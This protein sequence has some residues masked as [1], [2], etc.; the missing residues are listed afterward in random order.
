MQGMGWNQWRTAAAGALLALASTMASAAWPERAITLVV[1][2]TPGTGIDVV[3][4]QLAARLPN[5]LGQAV[6][7]DNVAGASGNIGTERVARSAPDGYTFVVQASTLVMNKG[8]FRT[9]AY[10][11]LRDL[12]PV[13]L[14]SWGTLLLVTN[15]NVQKVST[16][17]Q[18]VA[19]ARA[20]PGKLTYGTPGVGTP[21]HLAMAQLL[22]ANGLDMLQVPFKGTAGAVTELLGG[23]LD[24]M[25]LPVHVALPHIQTGKLV[26]LATGGDRRVPQ[27]P[28]VPTLAE[29]GLSVGNVDIWYGVLAPRG[30]PRA[31]VDRMDHEIAAILSQPDVASAFEAQGMIPAHQGPAAFGA[32]LARDAER[33]A[34]VI[35]AGHISA[36]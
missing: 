34:G 24:F 22:Q 11:P 2:Y 8:L 28:Q 4:R 1:P 16:A 17:A 18:M 21:H 7:V 35:R 36:E 31:I 10:D 30:T 9:L 33:W 6:V 23:R 26:A 5:V 13:T 14:T 25:F 29:A 19:A 12:E 27:L 20:Q 15:P 3:A 32:F